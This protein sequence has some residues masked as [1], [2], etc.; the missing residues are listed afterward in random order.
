M[1]AVQHSKG[2]MIQ[3]IRSRKGG[4]T[5]GVALTRYTTPP[6][7]WKY[8]LK[9]LPFWVLDSNGIPSCTSAG[10]VKFKRGYNSTYTFTKRMRACTLWAQLLNSLLDFYETLHSC[11]TL[12]ADVHEGIWLLS[13]MTKSH[14]QNKL[15]KNIL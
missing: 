5:G 7:S 1:V 10:F 15:T 3:L 14:L 12:P 2:E 4:C 13:K 6:F 8:K 9:N 11:N